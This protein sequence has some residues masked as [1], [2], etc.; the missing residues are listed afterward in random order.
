L[1]L[2]Q[3]DAQF[4]KELGRSSPRDFMYERV[5][6]LCIGDAMTTAKSL[7]NGINEIVKGGIATD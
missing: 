2:S 7:G 1:G 5:Q 4:T 3:R 6:P